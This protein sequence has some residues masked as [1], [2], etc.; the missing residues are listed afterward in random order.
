[1]K[2]KIY[3]ALLTLCMCL[4]TPLSAGATFVDDGYGQFG[5]GGSDPAP[6][7]APQPAPGPAPAPT[8]PTQP[9][10]G[11]GTSGKRKPVKKTSSYESVDITTLEKNQNLTLTVYY[12]DINDFYITADDKKVTFPKEVEEFTA[13]AYY[14]DQ[15]DGKLAKENTF[16]VL[17]DAGIHLIKDEKEQSYKKTDNAVGTAAD[18]EKY[19][20]KTYVLENAAGTYKLFYKKDTLCSV[21][22]DTQDIFVVS[23]LNEE[24]PALTI[25]EPEDSDETVTEEDKEKDKD[26]KEEKEDTKEEKEEQADTENI[27]EKPEETPS[28]DTSSQPDFAYLTVDATDKDA[29]FVTNAD[30]GDVWYREIAKDSVTEDKENSIFHIN[31]YADL[32]APIMLLRGIDK[33]DSKAVITK[34]APITCNIQVSESA[35]TED[36]LNFT[37]NIETT[38]DATFSYDVYQNG[39][40]IKSNSLTSNKEPMQVSVPLNLDPGTY[41]FKL[42]LYTENPA[43]ENKVMEDTLLAT[44]EKEEQVVSENTVSQDE[45]EITPEPEPEPEP[46]PFEMDNQ[47]RLLITA[48]SYGGNFIVY[49]IIFIIIRKIRKRKEDE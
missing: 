25:E 19:D 37:I 21:A 18:G 23:L 2:K 26:A 31:M 42:H 17:S 34:T 30:S 44:Y 10:S 1:M 22:F 5:G 11:S 43:F 28:E 38:T 41:E 16:P 6:A 13:S 8:T 35:I 47:T 29:M 27:K 45:P 20:V 3:I 39:E 9:S 32:N 14:T 7:P 46:E 49:L 33:L 48:A 36:V 40:S 15:K 12:K 4:A 24:K